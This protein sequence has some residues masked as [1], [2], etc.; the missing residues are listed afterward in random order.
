MDLADTDPCPGLRNTD[1]HCCC[2]T[3]DDVGFDALVLNEVAVEVEDEMEGED[4]KG[5]EGV[6]DEAAVEEVE[7]AVAVSVAGNHTHY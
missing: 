4:E 7:E 5:D 3:C 2:M 1:S 6:V